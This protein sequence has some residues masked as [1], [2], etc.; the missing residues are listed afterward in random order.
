MSATN[1]RRGRL[2]VTLAF[3]YCLFGVLE[4]VCGIVYFFFNDEFAS[5]I[6]DNVFIKLPEMESI[7]SFFIWI[8]VAIINVFIFI[9]SIFIMIAWQ[10]L[11]PVIAAVSIPSVIGGV[12]VF[13]K[14]RWA[15]KILFYT[16]FLYGLLFFPIGVAMTAFTVRAYNGEKVARRGNC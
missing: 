10:I 3:L 8:Y 15:L 5:L 9:A 2:I 14:E 12:G 4:A 11:A 16:S 1:H 13:L 7:L 6:F